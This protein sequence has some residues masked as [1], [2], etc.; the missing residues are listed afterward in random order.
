MRMIPG[1][2]RPSAGRLVWWVV[3]CFLALVAAF[4]LTERTVDWLWMGTLGYRPVFW[5]IIDLRFAL[6]A[7]AFIPLALYFSLN[8][9]R[10]MQ[11]MTA[12][13]Q[14]TGAPLDPALAELERSSLL[15]RALAGLLALFLAIGFASV[16]DDAVRFLYGGQ[17]GFVDPLLGRDVGFYVFRLPL[18]EAVRHG[19][20]LVA[21]VL[22]LAQ[23]GLGIGLGVF[24]DWARLDDVARTAT[25]S[26]LGW[27]LA[28]VAL[29][30]A[31]GYILDRYSL[32]YAASGTGG[33]RR[34]I[35]HV[36]LLAGPAAAGPGL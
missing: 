27:N 28:V 6:F 16:W 25:A 21:L 31:A 34:T 13:R 4:W 2:S 7:A 17:F 26:A 30:S 14:A 23:A 10:T 12:W 18:I 36:S 24:R 29:A 15:R 22:L 3:G 9:R 19:I 35:R 20:F 32:L 1:P 11:L 8:L 5:Q 33:P